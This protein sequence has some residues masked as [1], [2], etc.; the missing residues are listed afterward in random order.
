MTELSCASLD[1]PVYGCNVLKLTSTQVSEPINRRR[2]GYAP[3]TVDIDSGGE[4]MKLTNNQVTELVQWLHD[5]GTPPSVELEVKH[6]YLLAHSD[7][8]T[9]IIPAD[10]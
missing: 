1:S 7:G 6:G 8:R 5:V 3:T 4:S 9:V 10:H 2:R